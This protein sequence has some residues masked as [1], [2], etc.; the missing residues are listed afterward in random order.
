MRERI[1]NPYPFCIVQHQN[2]IQ[3]IPQL[4]HFSHLIRREILIIEEVPR[5]VLSRAY[6]TH[7]HH[8]LLFGDLVYFPIQEIAV[9]IKVVIF[10]GAF[11]DKLVGEFPF[12]VHEVFQ[13]LQKA[14]K[15]KIINICT[16]KICTKV[17][18]Q[19]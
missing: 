2:A 13:H 1:L 18:Y 14:Q 17:C 7:C 19:L 5:Q 8:L 6:R 11:A 4:G 9:S 12:E 16:I 10:K 15:Y 3:E